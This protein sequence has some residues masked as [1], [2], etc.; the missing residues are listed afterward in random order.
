MR[1]FK[2]T[3][4]GLFAM[5]AA[6]VAPASALE[7]SLLD[8]LDATWNNR[9]SSG[10]MFRMQD[11]DY[12]LVGKANVPGQQDLCTRDNC[13][14]LTGDPEPN[15]RLVN[16]G[17]AFGGVNADDGNLNYDKYDIVAATIKLTT[18][19]KLKYGEHWLAR[20][21]A[22]G[23]YDPANVNF[24]ETHA[25]LRHQ[26]LHSP[27]D[28]NVERTYAKGVNLLDAYVQYAFD[29]AGRSASISVGNQTVR[30]GESTL[31]AL[32]SLSEVNPPNQAVLRMPGYEIS[33]LFQP[34]P[35]ALFATDI[36]DNVSAE[37][38]YQFGWKK[39]VTDPQGSFFSDNDLLGRPGAPAYIT[40]GQHGEN[41][42]REQ[43]LGSPLDALSSSTVTVNL[44]PEIHPSDGGQYGARL[45]Y[46]ADWLNGGT[47]TAFY[48]LNYHSR[49]PYARITATAD[50]CARDSTNVVDSYV[51]CNGF[52]GSFPRLPGQ[53]GGEPLPIDTLGVQLEYPENIQ[54]YGFSFNTNLGSFSLAGEYSFRPNVPLQVAINDVIFAGLQPAFPAESFAIDPTGLASIVQLVG[55]GLGLSTSQLAAQFPGLLGDVLTLSQATFPGAQDAV[56]SFLA[57][58][59]NYGR[60]AARQ[61][62]PGYERMKVGQFDLTLIKA[63]S[64]NPFG[65]DQILQISEVGGT[66]VFGMPSRNILQ[67]EGAGPN[68]TSAQ[69]GADGTGNGGTPPNP[70]T[71]NPTQQADGFADSFA[72]GVRSITRFE[73]NDVVFGW[74][75]FPSI[76]AAWD[77]DGIAP[78]P[79]QNFVEG[80][81]EFTFSNDINMTQKLSARIAYQWFTGGGNHNTRKD[82][83]NLALSLAYTF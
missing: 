45:N 8:G 43:I 26:A 37:V 16:A 55:S 57:N 39:V 17:G 28:K 29:Y 15:Q 71:L 53:Q 20:V 22:L 83:D 64:Q 49:L 3:A 48:F 75:F 6:Y 24:E 35:V 31:V 30:W 10:V 19:L 7:F 50:S 51:S 62:I 59:R 9:L 40:L 69:K 72:W 81:K 33:E 74:S 23:F 32:N 4:T 38:F 76:I 82:R 42:N 77:I 36:V 58:Y 18:D 13:I 80:R 1:M 63:F 73:Y 46:F 47:E 34:V 79:I 27:R 2:R 44:G 12:N 78:S 61:V 25:D 56:P 5:V 52:N 54:M 65:A 41:P 60:I 21:R 68:A 67:F 14:S 66:Q 11:R 70:S